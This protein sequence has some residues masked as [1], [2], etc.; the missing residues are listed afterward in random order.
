MLKSVRYVS[1]SFNAVMEYDDDIKEKIKLAKLVVSEHKDKD[2]FICSVRNDFVDGIIEYHDCYDKY[3][4]R[5]LS[6]L[7]NVMFISPIFRDILP[8]SNTTLRYLLDGYFNRTVIVYGR[9][10]N[11][12]HIPIVINLREYI[13]KELIDKNIVYQYSN[14]DNILLVEQIGAISHINYNVQLIRALQHNPSHE[15]LVYMTSS[16]DV[17]SLVILED[18]YGY[19]FCDNVLKHYDLLS[20]Y[21]IKERLIELADYY[22]HDGLYL[23]LTRTELNVNTK[24]R[25]ERHIQECINTRNKHDSS[26]VEILEWTINNVTYHGN[27]TLYYKLLD[28]YKKE[29]NSGIYY[30]RTKMRFHKK[31]SYK[32]Y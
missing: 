23:H 32:W 10:N 24:N 3:V 20:K 22:G 28:F 27:K 6:R 29:M 2:R 1:H 17:L 16:A 30:Y 26:I 11:K 4:D 5:K 31:M 18:P 14:L 15:T 8:C 13:C 9:L 21:N 25:L 12:Y 19:R 7:Q